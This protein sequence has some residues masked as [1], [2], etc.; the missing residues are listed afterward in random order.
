MR[1]SY[2]V[3]VVGGGPAGSTA[4]FAAAKN[5]LTALLID[6][7]AFPRDKLCGR[8]LTGRSKALF[9]R[10]HET[11]WDNSLVNASDSI[12]F[13]AGDRRLDD[14]ENPSLES[15]PPDETLYFC[16]RREFDAFL[17]GL[18]K[19]AGVYL[20][21]GALID[22]IDFDGNQLELND[23]TRIAYR[24]RIGAD[25]VN[26]QVAREMFGRSFNPQTIGFGLEVEVPLAD[27][28]SRGNTVEIDFA[29]TEWGYGWIFP[30][31]KTYTV[32]VGGIHEL[33][34]DMKER[35]DAY[36]SLK[37]LSRSSYKVKGQYIP[38]GD[39]RKSPGRDNVLLCGDAAGVVDP[40]TGEGIA[41]ALETGELAGR[42]A[43]DAIA[44]GADR[45]QS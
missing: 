41:Y 8:L 21:L 25:G 19:E 14:P 35:L 22:R 39:Y 1:S 4:A 29:A 12:S 43:S 11:T 30:K 31:Q 6:K 3:I 32:G 36:L 5:G 26:S 33:N 13:W 38:F 45:T 37:G 34:P 44:A 18:A 20:A 17:L 16:M 24:V 9:E 42:S 2:D 40:I 7:R 10:I 15:L 28:P 23:G 27:M